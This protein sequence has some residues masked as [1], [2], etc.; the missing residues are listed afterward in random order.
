M[1]S[2][3]ASPSRPSQPH[4]PL[5]LSLSL[6]P[7]DVVVWPAR[8]PPVVSAVPW[9]AAKDGAAA[10][11]AARARVLKVVRMVDL[12][13]IWMVSQAFEPPQTHAVCRASPGPPTSR[14]TAGAARSVTEPRLG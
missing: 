9:A 10:I 11:A 12:R 2:R 8:M 5:S 1:P 3:P 14:H 7:Y 4:F 13:S 6:V